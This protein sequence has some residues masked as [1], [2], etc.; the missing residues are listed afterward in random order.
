MPAFVEFYHKNRKIILNLD[1]VC[2]I[3][4]ADS[5][6]LLIRCSNGEDYLA[7]GKEGQRVLDAI[8][9]HWLTSK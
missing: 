5:A 3:E 6:E 4:R 2:A 1:Q 9:C 8:Q 7:I